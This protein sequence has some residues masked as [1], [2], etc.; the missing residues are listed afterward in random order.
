MLQGK[1][2]DFTGQAD[3][4]GGLPYGRVIEIYGPP[5]AGKS[6]FL[7]ASPQKAIRPFDQCS[8]HR[9]NIAANALLAGASVVW[10]DASYML[11]SRRLKDLL[12]NAFQQDKETTQAETS[13]PSLDDNM[14]RFHHF[15]VPTLPH[16]IALLVHSTP[17]FPPRDVNLLV[18][19]SVSTLFT[20]AF[21]QS[22]RFANSKTSGKK[23]D[24]AQWATNRR[25]AVMGD[26][27][28]ALGKLAATRN[29]AVVLTSQTTTK[30]RTDSAAL[31]QPAISGTA[32]ESGITCRILLFRDWRA[33]ADGQ[34]SEEARSIDPDLRYA[35]VTKIG[36]VSSDGFGDIVPFAID[37]HGL[38]EINVSPSAIGV[39]EPTVP[40]RA[41]L[42]RKREG[43]EIADSAS[44]SEGLS[45]DDEFG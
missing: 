24:V 1:P 40:R 22:D 28:A 5:G 38:H 9:I 12:I 15:T 4:F 45:T 14:S 30:L 31:L 33:A 7:Y 29:M 41:S 27:I 21:A 26:L 16:L 19:D 2:L 8:L 44:D 39:Q 11:N 37:N 23:S 20:Q 18:I 36:G 43:D 35:A 6:L 25:W 34:S 10:I 42:K 32:W 3:V 17:T 13:K